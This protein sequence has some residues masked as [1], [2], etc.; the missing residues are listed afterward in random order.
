MLCGHPWEEECSKQR[1]NL[2]K[3]AEVGACLDYQR[4]PVCLEHRK[5]GEEWKIMRTLLMAHDYLPPYTL[6]FL[7]MNQEALRQL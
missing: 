4:R 1:E 3:Y 7:W 5:K 2:C 6:L